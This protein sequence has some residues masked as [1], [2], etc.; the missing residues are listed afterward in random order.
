MICQCERCKTRISVFWYPITVGERT[1]YLCDDCMFRFVM[2]MK[3]DD[4]DGADE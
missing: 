4:K 2:W 1:I 3:R